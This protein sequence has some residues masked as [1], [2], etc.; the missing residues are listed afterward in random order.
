MDSR[1]PLNLDADALFRHRDWAVHLARSLVREREEA[2]VL[3]QDALTAAWV[4]SPGRGVHLRAWLS[5]VLQRKAASR[6]RELGRRSERERLAARSE[7]VQANS[8]ITERADLHTRL[9]EHVLALPDA[10][11][12]VLL[13]RYFEGWSPATIAKHEDCALSTINNR[14]THARQ[15]L[16]ERLERE[17]KGPH[18]M[19]AYGPLLAGRSMAAKTGTPL[20]ALS[21][22]WALG[23]GTIV[24]AIAIWSRPR[25]PEHSP[26]PTSALALGSE[27]LPLDRGIARDALAALEP[28][29]S[30]AALEAPDPAAQSAR[31]ADDGL[32]HGRL[33]SAPDGLEAPLTEPAT[34]VF[35]NAS[36]ALLVPRESG[37]PGEFLFHSYTRLPSNQYMPDAITGESVT[38]N[39]GTWTMEVPEIDLVLARVY[40]G[41]DDWEI[42]GERIVPAGSRSV[43]VLVRPYPSG[44]LHVLDEKGASIK[45]GLQVRSE[46]SLPFGR[47]VKIHMKR[48]EGSGREPSKRPNHRTA[49]EPN[50]DLVLLADG[51]QSPVQISSREYGR[52]LWV[53][54]PGYAWKKIPWPAFETEGQVTLTPVGELEIEIVGLN[55]TDAS[56]DLDLFRDNVYVLSWFDIREAGRYTASGCNAGAHEI[57]LKR[58]AGSGSAEVHKDSLWIAPGEK[59]RTILDLSTLPRTAKGSATVRVLPPNPGFVK[60][61]SIQLKL[62]GHGRPGGLDALQLTHKLRD[63]TPQDGRRVGQFAEL[64]EGRYTLVA[65]PLGATRTFEVSAGQDTVVDLDISQLARVAATPRPG[66]TASHGASSN[67]VLR[68]RRLTGPDGSKPGHMGSVIAS[69]GG[70]TFACEPGPILLAIEGLDGQGIGPVVRVDAVPG[71]NRFEISIDERQALRLELTLAGVPQKLASE[72]HATLRQVLRFEQAGF[73]A[74]LSKVIQSPQPEGLVTLHARVDFLDPGTYDLVFDDDSPKSIEGLPVTPL[75]IRPGKPLVHELVYREH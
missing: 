60:A 17:G 70:W 35:A 44:K 45:D 18:W 36:D 72:W 49:P 23:A 12:V 14:L 29:E 38:A 1:D 58:Q 9:V 20:L 57:R 34:L 48:I 63:Y 6:Y 41:T 71:L 33:F 19:S 32:L 42:V 53:G 39:D 47:S 37:A 26:E 51:A 4:R 3:A 61:D 43:E 40:G 5:R 65:L 66:G 75:M 28:A 25:T 27:A 15:A 46:F 54:K 10:Y 21:L 8:E 16:R 62:S 24:A 74:L 67:S 22:K 31:A 56:F 11:S 55:D 30:R 68:W 7:A 64:P 50:S 59:T 13:Q 2:E 73:P 69:N 52:N